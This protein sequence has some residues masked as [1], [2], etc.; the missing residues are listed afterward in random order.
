MCTEWNTII[1]NH[2]FIFALDKEK[3]RMWECNNQQKKEKKLIHIG[4][5]WCKTTNNH[6]KN[7]G[8]FILAK[9]MLF[10]SLFFFCIIWCSRLPYRK[11]PKTVLLSAWINTSLFNYTHAKC[12]W[13]IVLFIFFCCSLYF[14]LFTS[15]IIRIFVMFCWLFVC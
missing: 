7:Q 2:A 6:E 11:K 12:M 13:I 15:I 10:L 4:S 8:N 1:C 3:E 14:S 5:S 9:I